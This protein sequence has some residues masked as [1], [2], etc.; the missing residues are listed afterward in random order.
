MNGVYVSQRGYQPVCQGLDSTGELV[1][2]MRMKAPWHQ[3]MFPVSYG[4]DF[5][6]EWMYKSMF[7]KG[8]EWDS[9]DSVEQTFACTSRTL[10]RKI[11]TEPRS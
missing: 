10:L 3:K 4:G 6:I 11:K 2:A 8:I 9:Q 5:A 7:E 1:W